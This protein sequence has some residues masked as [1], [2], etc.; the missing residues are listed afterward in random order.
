MQRLNHPNVVKAIAV[1]PDLA[2][3]RSKLPLMCMEFCSKGDLRQVLNR[4]ENCCGLCEAEVRSLISDVK[5]AVQYLH[6]MKI[7]HRDLKPENI[8]LQQ[9]ED[10]IVY[11][12]IDLG[13][14]K[15]LDQSSICTSFV[16]TLQYLAPELFMSKTY[17]YS[18]DYWS[19]GLVSHEVITGVRPFLPNMAPVSWMTHVREKSSDDIC[20]YKAEDGTIVFSKEL[21]LQN[22]ISSCLKCY[23]EK[24]LKLLLEWDAA[25]RGRILNRNKELQIV[26]FDLI[27]D[28][29]SKKIINVFS[30]PSYQ[31]LS[32]EID[33]STA[34]STLQ[35]WIERDTRI[36][37]QEQELLLSSGQPFDISKEACQ[38]WVPQ[39]L[40]NQNV[41]TMVYVYHRGSLAIQNFAPSVPQTVSKM[42]EEPRNKVEFVHQKRAWAHAVFFLQQEMELY[43]AFLQAY[44]VKM[45]HVISSNAKLNEQTQAVVSHLQQVEAQ[46]QLI[47]ESLHFDE[48]QA[49]KIGFFSEEVMHSWSKMNASVGRRI[50][51]LKEIVSQLESK[52]DV[53]NGKTMD[54]QRNPYT[55]M[56]DH[57]VLMSL[58]EEGQKRYD[59]LRRR[60]KE[61]RYEQTDNVEMVKIVYNCLKH[62]DKL[63]RDKTFNAHLQQV[64]DVQM[65]IEQLWNPL[66]SSVQVINKVQMELKQTQLDRQHDIWLQMTQ[67]S[68][69]GFT[70][71]RDLTKSH[72]VYRPVVITTSQPLSTSMSIDN[73]EDKTEILVPTSE[74]SF[75]EPKQFRL[76]ASSVQPALVSNDQAYRDPPEQMSVSLSN[77]QCDSSAMIDYNVSLRYATQDLMNES[78]QHYRRVLNEDQSLDW[79]FLEKQ[80]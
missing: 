38:C 77:S 78:F 16:G 17:N 7:T 46:L 61:N 33:D 45:L 63:L 60:P 42:M 56:A 18:V 40:N 12:L 75:T 67:D 20:A 11:K 74:H 72:A 79:A 48:D 34:V 66:N 50:A 10:R 36:P 6:S 55:K 35:T 69:N 73:R 71:P 41:N 62:R 8:V 27:E 28:I 53:A 47:L 24:W 14:A 70:V 43:H 65:E 76:T 29:L 13:Y 37:V 9:E 64:I 21:F 68:C 52:C 23:V 54:L 26:V 22:H 30:V 1:P 39:T 57:E 5:S 31:N 49:K 44:R 80:D 32:Y 25:K 4:S 58:L 15:E 2:V 59:S 3:L 51:K 19:L